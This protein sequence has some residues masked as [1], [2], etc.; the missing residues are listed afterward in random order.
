MSG[1]S[2]TP[3][4]DHEIRNLVTSFDTKDN[5]VRAAVWQQLRDQGDR[6]L[7]FF[8]DLFTVARR[9][10]VRRDI[11]FHCT[12]FARTSNVAF[13]IGLM[14]AEDKSSIVRYRGCGVL[15]YSLRPD[16]LPILNK[17]LSHSDSKTVED[18]K[19][20]IDAIQRRNHH[21][22]IDRRHT[23]QF[24]WAVDDGGTAKPDDQL[25]QQ[26]GTLGV[27]H[28]IRRWLGRGVGH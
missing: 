19:A 9:L 18:A 25:P 6:V 10:E 2:V 20:A 17:Q 23:G 13:R 22:F 7:P 14:A 26:S 4:D 27:F 5:A 8:A 24:F 12:R 3:M 15:A 1:R 16:A 28:V 21:Y 11:A